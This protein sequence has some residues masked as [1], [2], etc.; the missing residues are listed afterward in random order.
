[1]A[2]G[3]E[4]KAR[5]TADVS[6]FV[7][8]SRNM[9]RAAGTADASIRQ[10]REQLE[11]LQRTSG[12][13]ASS[14]RPVANAARAARDAAQQSA[15]SIRDLQGGL[16]Q[17]A[18]AFDASSSSADRYS[19]STQKASNATKVTAASLRAMGR[20][21]QRLN[22]QRNI[23]L[24][25][26]SR[27]QRLT[28]QQARALR[29]LDLQINSLEQQYTKLNREQRQVV[30]TSRALVQAQQTAT[31]GLRSMNRFAQEAVQ[32]ERQLQREQEKAARA[33]EKQAAKAREAAQANDRMSRS[34]RDA[35][36]AA[37]RF[38]ESLFSIR[39]VL[40][41]V[42]DGFRSVQ[43]AVI[44]AGTV[45]ADAFSRQEVATA[46]LSRVTQESRS[47]VRE[48]A[49]TF[50]DMSEAI[51]VSFDELARIGV[52]GSQVGIA[53]TAMVDFTETVALFSATTDVAEDEAALLFARITE[54]LGLDDSNIR[55]LGASVSE[56]G[57]NSAA[58][59]QEILT[60]TESIATVATQAGLSETAVIGLGGAM[61]SLRIRPELARGAVQRVFLQLEQAVNGT[62]GG[63]ETL[64][65]ITGM[66]EDELRSLRDTNTDQFF[67]TVM[68]ALGGVADSGQ[69][70]IPV[71]R[72]IGINNTRD[73]DVVARLAGNYQLLDDAVQLSTRS[74]A[75]ATFL[76]QESSRIFDTLTA[77]VQIFR[78]TWENTFFAIVEAVAPVVQEIVEFGTAVGNMVGNFAEANPEITAVVVVLTSLVGILGTL[79]IA[80]AA[81]S[82]GYIAM[83]QALAALTAATATN[84]AAASANTAAT[85]AQTGALTG[86]TAAA[87][88][89]AVA[90]RAAALAHPVTAVI[91]VTTAL[92][93]AAA[94]WDAF[95]SDV[96]RANDKLIESQQAHLQAAGGMD[97]L[98]LAVREDTRAWEETVDARR[99]FITESGRAVDMALSGAQLMNQ[100]DTARLTTT[101][102]LSEA[103]KEQREQR[104]LAAQAEL[105]YERAVHGTVAGL[106]RRRSQMEGDTSA[107]DRQIDKQ[108]SLRQAVKENSDEVDAQTVA[109]GEATFA[110]LEASQQSAV[111]ESG[112]LS[113]AEAMRAL[114]DRG[115]NLISDMNQGLVKEMKNAGEGAEFLRQRAD[116]LRSSME[117]GEATGQYFADMLN[118]ITA[119]I[120][121]MDTG[122]EQ[123]AQK[124]EELADTLEAGGLSLEEARDATNFLNEST[125]E[126]ANG[127]QV[128]RQ[129][130]IELDTQAAVLEST[131]MGTSFTVQDLVDGF[132]SFHDPLAIWNDLQQEANEAAREADENFTGMAE[133]SLPAYASALDDSIAAQ[134]NWANNLL[135]IA[136]EVPPQVTAQLAAMGQDGAQIVQQMADAIA[137][138]D[139]STVDQIA[140]AFQDMG[141]D[142]NT[143]F[144]LA[145]TQFIGQAQ[146]SG[147]TAGFEFVGELLDQVAAG[148]ISMGEAVDRMTEYAEEEFANADPVI[149]AQ[150]NNTRAIEK[151]NATLLQ[152]Q[153]AFRQMNDEAEVEPEFNSGGWWDSLKSWYYNTLDWLNSLRNQF[154]S[155]LNMMSGR[156][157]F[158]GIGGRGS[159]SYADGGWVRGEGGP[160]QD[161]IPAMLSDNEFVV[162]ARSA[163]EFG[164]LLEWINSG[165][166]NAGSAP[167]LSPNFVP[168]DIFEMPRRPLND[169]ATWLPEAVNRAATSTIPRVQDRIVMTI[170]NQYPQ[171]EPTSV[172]VN[173]ALAFAGAL[174][175]LG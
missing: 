122:T 151:L 141:D 77:R 90:L 138:G 129:E 127:A 85:T 8:A 38:D 135:T 163:R 29:T 126:L 165:Q 114:N 34:M 56:L 73:A 121:Q 159:A 120:V 144:A 172:T 72:E 168:D 13:A 94:A 161:K 152:T 102:E 96:D 133:V 35:S 2:A 162:N 91:A 157:A 69:N 48:L 26:Q 5:I 142:V 25:I 167:I 95:N 149:Q 19:S 86:L 156:S 170:N 40:T 17:S 112:I 150:M 65:R 76:Q 27:E 16:R 68:E 10:L 81:V 11:A 64:V 51:P 99:E 103:E 132:K 115:V 58:T 59:E 158:S 23:L 79:G 20:D 164:P 15:Q 30:D 53:N 66:T 153:S 125:A 70:L 134:A 130:L 83:Q 60:T 175:G 128:T 87:G 98:K 173:R 36:R 44:R 80:V 110:W 111:L 37:G 106:K 46:Q 136:Q 52:L 22:D 75:E 104:R 57:S 31:S 82:R 147:D 116:D 93:G 6:S 131:F 32:A 124:Y 117:A 143:Q 7:Q 101:R 1:M 148:E 50:R 78:N 12:T 100:A 9:A 113:N 71:L 4:A 47:E 92:V 146:Q 84:S 140:Q 97:R 54:M 42:E 33:A 123:A 55:N 63:M 14:M 119:G 62:A 166:N 108:E 88:R 49:D 137:T 169:M 109:F 174:D 3:F 118:M 18:Q 154:R 67:F 61:A 105:D 21:M 160:R 41:D 28:E 107:I 145:M 43:R 39:S 24:Q 155:V 139:D 171:A 89:A 45:M 74:F